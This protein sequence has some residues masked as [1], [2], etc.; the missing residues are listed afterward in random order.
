MIIIITFCEEG[1]VIIPILQ[2]NKRKHRELNLATVM[3]QF[4]LGRDGILKQPYPTPEYAF[5]SASLR[6]VSSESPLKSWMQCQQDRTL[7]KASQDFL[8]S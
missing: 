8:F 3:T 5:P 4:T 6:A 1:T 7:R 2:T